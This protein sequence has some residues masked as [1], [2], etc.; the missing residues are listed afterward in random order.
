M[1]GLLKVWS[2]REHAARREDFWQGLLRSDR[3]V[4]VLH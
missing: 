3:E 2:G 4:T 1:E